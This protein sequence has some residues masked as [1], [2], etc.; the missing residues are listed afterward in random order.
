MYCIDLSKAHIFRVLFH[1]TAIS[2]YYFAIYYDIN[3]VAF[4]KS[5]EKTLARPGMGGRSRFLSYWCLVSKKK[6]LRTEN[7]YFFYKTH[8]EA[9]QISAMVIQLH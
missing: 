7:K 9:E 2:Q 1:S 6:Y 3:Y 4:P 5:L 8:R